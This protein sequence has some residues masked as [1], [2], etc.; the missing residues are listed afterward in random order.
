MNLRIVK[1]TIDKT[2]DY[3]V[4]YGLPGGFKDTLIWKERAGPFA[5]VDEAGTYVR[6]T[7]N[8]PVTKFEIIWE[9][10]TGEL[11]PSERTVSSVSAAPIQR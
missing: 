2:V 3:L 9:T 1:R 7:L 5:T 11:L 4:E 8:P 6:N 10:R